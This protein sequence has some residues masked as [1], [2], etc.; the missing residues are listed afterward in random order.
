MIVK[1]LFKDTATNEEY[2]MLFGNLYKKWQTQL[3]EYWRKGIMTDKQ[4]DEL[5]EECAA[6]ILDCLS[7]VVPEIEDD[8]ALGELILQK[9]LDTYKLVNSNK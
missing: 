7:R 8:G 1:I 4:I 6:E 3:E 9:A 2:A 5:V